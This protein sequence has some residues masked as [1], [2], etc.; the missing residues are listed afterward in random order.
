[1]PT[2]CALRFSSE[3]SDKCKE[4]CSSCEKDSLNRLY[5]IYRTRE[6]TDK[7]AFPGYTGPFGTD[8]DRFQTVP[9]EQKP[10]PNGSVR[11]RPVPCER[12]RR[13]SFSQWYLVVKMYK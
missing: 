3:T 6:H 12:S 4:A 7:V 13:L 5:I 11:F 10:I 2:A 1:M 9:C 8:R